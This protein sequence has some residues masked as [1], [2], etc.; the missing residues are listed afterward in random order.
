M[1]KVITAE[2]FIKAF[3]ASFWDHVEW[4]SEE[5]RTKVM[6]EMVKEGYDADEVA[7]MSDA[8]SSLQSKAGDSYVPDYASDLLYVSERD[9]EDDFLAIEEDEDDEDEE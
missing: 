6:Y 5:I 2:A 3:N 4:I 1:G 7:R 9:L 8:F